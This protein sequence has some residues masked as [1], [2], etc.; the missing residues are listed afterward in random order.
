MLKLRII[1]KIL[2]IFFLNLNYLYSHHKDGQGKIIEVNL[3]KDKITILNENCAFKAEQISE[4]KNNPSDK[5]VGPPT[6]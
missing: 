5:K 1:L 4:P 2:I 6:E 3:D